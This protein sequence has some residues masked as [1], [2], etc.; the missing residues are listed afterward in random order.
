M[1]K[2]TKVKVIRHSSIIALALLLA[3]TIIG[4]QGCKKT[5]LDKQDFKTEYQT[6]LLTNGIYYFG[7]VENMGSRFIELKD[8]YFIKTVQNP[9]TKQLENKLL[10]KSKELHKPDRMYI[11]LQQVLTIEPVSSDS[12]IVQLI[13]GAAKPEPSSPVSK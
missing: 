10:A 8:V 5:G 12:K 9:D 4:L 13:H 2:E 6:I 1:K 11:S 7:K 3:I